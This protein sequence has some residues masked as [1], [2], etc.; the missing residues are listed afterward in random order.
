MGSCWYLLVFL[1]ISFLFWVGPIGLGVGFIEVGE[2]C[3]D[4]RLVLK[5]VVCV[6]WF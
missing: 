4:G 1:F 5:V 6:S 2:V 3:G